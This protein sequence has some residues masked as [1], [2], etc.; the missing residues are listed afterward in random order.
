MRIAKVINKT[1]QGIPLLVKDGDSNK[2]ITVPKKGPSGFISIAE[3]LLTDQ[4][5]RLVAQG[6][7]QIK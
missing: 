1:K 3:D 6:K 5:K 2:T 4:A 7:L